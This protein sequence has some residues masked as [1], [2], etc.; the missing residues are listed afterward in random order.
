MDEGS[1]PT[2]PIF[3]IWRY[4]KMAKTLNFNTIKREYFTVTLPDEEKTTI[5]I[6]TPN[7]ALFQELINLS[8]SSQINQEDTNEV[9]DLMDDLYTTI[10]KVMSI[11]KGGIHI[12][13]EKLEECLD[14]ESLLIFFKSYLEFING[15]KNR[16]N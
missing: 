7:K 13:R 12:S 5:M 16:K 6:G 4:F 11:N 1:Y 10:A 8:K 14:F 15:I 2:R 3:I 9:N